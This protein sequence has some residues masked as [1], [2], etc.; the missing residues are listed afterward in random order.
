MAVGAPLFAEI[1][2][3]Y[4]ELFTK[5]DWMLLAE[6]IPEDTRL[7]NLAAQM[8]DDLLDMKDWEDAVG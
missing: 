8:A 2:D 6:S 3:L 1:A 7:G 5:D 4:P